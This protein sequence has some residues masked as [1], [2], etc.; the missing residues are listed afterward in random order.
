M[1]TLDNS[2]NNKSKS[3]KQEALNTFIK[4]NK[5]QITTLVIG[6]IKGFSKLPLD[7]KIRIVVISA[8]VVAIAGVTYSV[9]DK[10]NKNKSEEQTESN[11]DS[12]DTS[13]DTA[14]EHKKAA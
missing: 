5:E 6:L 9:V 10:M 12:K 11:D 8:T 14:T 2:K 1:S 7:T 3:A 13:K 4:N